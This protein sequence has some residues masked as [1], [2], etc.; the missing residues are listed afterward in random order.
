MFVCISKGSKSSFAITACP[1][2]PIPATKGS[3]GRVK[4]ADGSAAEAEY[5]DFSAESSKGLA[6]G[7]G[8][9]AH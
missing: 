9:W 7:M 3:A 6:A 5:H 2:P 4:A 1:F 8:R